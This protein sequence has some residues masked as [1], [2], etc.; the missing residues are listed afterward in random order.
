VI[1]A[2][3]TRHYKSK[4]ENLREIAKQLGVAHI[5]E[6]SV[7][8]SADTVRMNLQLIEAATNSP[9]WA[10]TIDRALTDILSLESEV[11][12]TVADQLR[13][14]LTGE[15]AQAIAAKPTD[16]PEAYDAYLRGLA[17]T[18]KSGGFEPANVIP[19]RQYLK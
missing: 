3:S 15:E 4:P 2:T 7:Q 13:A 18:L 10:D 5:L 1:S 9:V 14:K 12:T 6:G 16:N 17:Y 19:A 8:K 11:A